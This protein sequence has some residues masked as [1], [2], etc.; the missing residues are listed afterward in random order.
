M[1]SL[2]WEIVWHLPRRIPS[3]Q[4]CHFK[5]TLQRFFVWM[6]VLRP[7]MQRNVIEVK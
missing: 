6:G 1:A 3:T 4:K 7:T 2:S 5:K